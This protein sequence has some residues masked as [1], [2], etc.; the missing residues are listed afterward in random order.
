MNVLFSSDNNYAQH[1]GVAIYSLLKHNQAADTISVYVVDNGIEDVNK[2]NLQTIVS[3]FA[4]STIYYISFDSWKEQLHLDLAWPI[5]LSSYARLFLASMLP[6]DVE[7]VI[8]MDCDMIVCDGLMDLW[9]YNLQGNVVGAVQDTVSTVKLSIGLMPTD[10]YF[11]AGM[12]LVDV[13]AWREHG[14]EQMCLD[15]ISTHNGRV[16]HHDQGVL[17]GVFRNA[18]TCLPLRYNIMTIHYLLSQ[19]AI[20][21]FFKDESPFYCSDD[22]EEAKKNPAILHFTPSF[23]TRPW[24]KSCMHPLRYLYWDTLAN[25]PWRGAQPEADKDKWYVKVINWW[26]RC[27]KR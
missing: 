8:Y 11:N 15:F 6:D 17:N 22:V 27:V 9:S 21:K 25:T 14:K 18:W 20:K 5:S 4:N 3:E 13:K 1:L 12:L 10:S 2:D 23:T 16:V 7:R 19:K 26:H 24:V